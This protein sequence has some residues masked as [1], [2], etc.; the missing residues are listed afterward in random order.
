[1][2]FAG[3]VSFIIATA[4]QQ[5]W[6][7]RTTSSLSSLYYG[8]GQDR[9][10]GAKIGYLDSNVVLKITDSA[11]GFFYVQLSQYHHAYIEKKF[12]LKDSSFLEKPYYLTDSWMARGTDSGYDI[13]SIR[14]DEHLPYKSQMLINPAKIVIDIYGATSN[15]NWITQLQSLKEITNIYYDQTEDDVL[16]ITIDLK[17]QQH[18]GY[19]IGYAGK[20]MIIKVKRQPDLTNLKKL[21]I[22]I[23][24]GHGGENT[25][26][27]GRRYHAQEKTYTLLFAKAFEKYLKKFGIKTIMTRTK[28]TTF[29]NSDRLLFL[30]QQQPDFV[31]SFH[32]NSAGNP[33]IRGS[34]TY[35]KY[36]GFRPL[37]QAILKRMLAAEP[38]E[39][40]NVGN[41]NFFLNSLTDFPNCLLEIAFLS[42]SKD[43]KK[44][45][46][47]SFREL[48]AKQVYKGI[49][50][51]LTKCREL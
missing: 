18:W 40:G 41:F 21:K 33:D 26:S 13:V 15:T 48:V 1:L 50:D 12:V 45:I 37:S 29:P 7:G 23:D 28:D 32:F 5:H 39:Y 16:R 14:I 3:F 6:Y 24:A 44:I 42:N 17:H 46:G 43:E 19:S 22:A 11:Q 25:G 30:Q 35:Y 47:A 8:L 27:A 4:Q 2:L 36:I 10:G 31:I 34:S 51:W 9:L 38:H 49:T 20:N